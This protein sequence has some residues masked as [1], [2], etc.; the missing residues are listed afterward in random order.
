LDSADTESS[1]LELS[2]IGWEETTQS[3]DGSPQG[4]FMVRDLEFL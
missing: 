1:E 3:K 4:L 2:W